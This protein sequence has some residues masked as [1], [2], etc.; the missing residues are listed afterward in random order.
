[1]SYDYTD[2]P[3]PRDLDLIPHGEVATV[4]MHIL[5]GG[6]GE[7]NL[8]KRAQ[9]GAEMLDLELV[10]VDGPYSRRKFW[11]KFVLEGTTDG[12]AKAGKISRGVLRTILE[13]ARGIKPDDTSP[14]ARA[15]RTVSLKDFDNLT[16]IAKIG[17]E[18][19]KPK[20]DN[21]GKPTGENW[22]DKNIIASVITPDKTDW[23]PVE[24]APPFNGGGGAAAASS[25]PA[26]PAA[27]VKR[28]GWATDKGES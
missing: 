19:G 7:D 13:S 24:Q 10:V 18:K 9:S 28:P 26:A 15:L 1:M 6:V 23:H 22:P 16:F 25:G 21:N 14:Q 4:T 20:T 12:H 8:L 2:T 5:A 11:E 3:P 27:P 17:I